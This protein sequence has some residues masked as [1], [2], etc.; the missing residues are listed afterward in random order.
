LSVTTHSKALCCRRSILLFLFVIGG[1]AA[2]VSARL[3]ALLAPKMQTPAL[4]YA[5]RRINISK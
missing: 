2:T 3:L 5:G 1:S 4:R